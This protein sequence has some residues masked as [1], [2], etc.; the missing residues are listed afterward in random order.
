MNATEVNIASVQPFREWLLAQVKACPQ[1]GPMAGA[2]PVFL[3]R[4]DQSTLAVRWALSPDSWA[5]VAVRPFLPQVRVGL[6]T[7]N[8][9]QNE[10]LEKKVEETGDTMSEYLEA[11]FAEADLDWPHPPVE[12]YR[13]QQKLFYFATPLDLERLDDLTTPAIR[14][15]TLKMLLGYWAGFGKAWKR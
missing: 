13:E 4:E 8:R 10:E 7:E 12:H 1:L 3:D 14:E 2:E 9:W 6:C 5:E 15:K 11:A